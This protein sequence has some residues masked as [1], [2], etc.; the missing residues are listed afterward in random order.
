[1]SI[2]TLVEVR[3]YSNNSF[4]MVIDNKYPV[5]VCITS[6][7]SNVVDFDFMQTIVLN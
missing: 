5:S 3:V 6:I 1:M 7:S 4:I 2:I